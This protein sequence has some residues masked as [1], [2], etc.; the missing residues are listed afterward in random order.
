MNPINN[1]SVKEGFRQRNESNAR[2]KE[3]QIKDKLSRDIGELVKKPT[4]KGGPFIAL[5]VALGIVGAALAGEFEAFVGGFAIGMIVWGCA[6]LYVRSFNNKLDSTKKQ[7]EEDAQALIRQAYLGADEAT[8]KEITE[9]DC[10]VKQ[11]SQQILKNQMNFKGMVDHTLSMF[12]RM[13]SHVDAGSNKK[14]VE[15]DFTYEVTREG[16][17]YSYQSAYTN[18]QD[19]YNFDKQRYRNLKSASEC[20][21]L[22]RALAKL[23]KSRIERLYPENTI[24]IK[25][26]HVDARV[27]LHFKEANKNFVPA[28]DIF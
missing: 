14:F 24:I 6:N 5:G 4:F 2:V 11:Y 21:G 22:A 10:E 15:G 19:D 1:S 13:V 27:T 26:S 7:L 17:I 16:I 20:E 12:Q 28:K 8:Q 9:Y 18:S 25:V 23:T 3:A